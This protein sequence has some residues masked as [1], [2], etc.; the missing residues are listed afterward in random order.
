MTMTEVTYGL[1]IDDVA[2]VAPRSGRWF[3]GPIVLS[4]ELV[5]SDDVLA[6]QDLL[7]LIQSITKMAAAKMPPG[8]TTDITITACPS[9]GPYARHTV[10]TVG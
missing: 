7:Y 6:G 8:K 1:S 5:V 3:S 4:G 10:I 2:P 9:P